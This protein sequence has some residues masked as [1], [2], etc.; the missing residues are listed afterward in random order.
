MLA[1]MNVGAICNIANL[2]YTAQHGF[3]SLFY[4]LLASLVFF[5]PVGFISAELATG[6]PKK[7]GVYLWV[8]EALGD[9]ASFVAIWL[10]WIENVIWYPTILA[11]I[12][13]T[14]SHIFNP[15][16]AENNLYVFAVVLIVIW[17]V[18]IMNFWGMKFS[19]VTML[20]IGEP[21]SGC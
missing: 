5:L 12:A 3:S 7:G 8:R 11:Y 13:T 4:Y 14:L 6:W 21:N 9:K 17:A 15:Q 10:Q 2:P 16:L 1:M 18:T 20:G 19:G